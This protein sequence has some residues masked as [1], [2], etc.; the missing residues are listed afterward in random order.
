MVES[1]HNTSKILGRRVKNQ[2]V[3]RIHLW[4]NQ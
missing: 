4:K 3:Q 1:K 2:G